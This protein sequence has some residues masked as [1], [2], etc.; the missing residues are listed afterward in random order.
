MT[1]V[2]LTGYVTETG[3]LR[4]HMPEGFPAGEVE[5]WVEQVHISGENGT[6]HDDEKPY[7][8][9]EITAMVTPHPKS[10]AE[11]VALGHTGGWEHKGIEDSVEWLED[12]RRKR[13][14]SRG[15]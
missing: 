5:I 15:W 2:K 11:I 1:T 6:Q 14:E 4:A 9:E 3:E 13:R 7:T 12:Q 8:E 10:G